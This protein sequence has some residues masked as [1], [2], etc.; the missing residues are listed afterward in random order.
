MEY[1]SKE[2]AAKCLEEGKVQIMGIDV[3][4]S[5]YQ[6]KSNRG[7]LNNNLYVKNLPQ[8]NREELEEKL[9]VIQKDSN[10]KIII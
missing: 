7:S 6:S 2:S 9:K 4:V 8:L 10:F 1:T 5:E 3:A